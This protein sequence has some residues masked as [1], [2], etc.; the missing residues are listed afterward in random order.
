MKRLFSALAIVLA[1][2]LN[3]LAVGQR[4]NL[5]LILADDYGLDG[6]SCYG[7]D[8]FKGRTPNIDALA[9]SGIRF[10]NAYSTPLC[11]PT[12]CLLNTGR[13]GFRTGG[14][15]NQTAGQPKAAGEPSL[16]RML[17]QAG[18]ATG[19]AGKWRQM[20]E[21]P[22]DWGFDEFI[23]DPTAGG[24]YWKSSYTRNGQLV[25]TGKE[26]YCPDGCM[27]FTLDFIRRHRDGPFYLYFPTHLVHGPILRTPDSQPGGNLYN[28]NVAYLD[29]QV[30]EIVAEIDRLGLRENTLI[31]FTS[32][33]GTAGKSGTLGGRQI[34]GHKGTM[35][36][37]GSHVPFIANWKG[38]APAGSVLKDLVDF[39]DVF[40][41]FAEL[42]GVKMPEGIKFDGRSF[43]AQLD[44]QAGNPREW[45]YVQLGGKWFARNAGWKLNQSRELFDLREA[46]F[47]ERPVAVEGQSDA[48]KA[49]RGRL[50]AVLDELN[51]AAGKNSVDRDPAAK[52][53]GKANQAKKK[54]RR[55][56]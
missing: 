19:M 27:D 22:G 25:E 41:T 55:A 37:G 33:N 18:Y 44:G 38:V 36:E 48:A 17:K 23:T 40:P 4:P 47:L 32:D 42:A 6:V 46:P 43:A 12:R 16:A 28:E 51:P 24:W 35:L 31:L 1:A 20:G 56:S 50:Q 3:L 8:R 21:S 26:V 34:H 14:T 11:G 53:I 52:K 2:S 39:S 45:V 7:S 9:K 54:A 15:Q 13:Y 49:A 10:E 30:G 29:K 5:V